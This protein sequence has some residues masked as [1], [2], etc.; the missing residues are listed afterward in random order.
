M[1]NFGIDARKVGTA[2]INDFEMAGEEIDFNKGHSLEGNV[3]KRNRRN[4]DGLSRLA[5]LARM[6]SE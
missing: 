6:R 3:R 4:K 1:T 5:Q 2:M